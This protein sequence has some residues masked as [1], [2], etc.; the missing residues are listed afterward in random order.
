MISILHCIIPSSPW[1]FTKKGQGHPNPDDK[2]QAEK[3]E[4][5]YLKVE[6]VEAEEQIL[7]S[8]LLV[9]CLF[10]SQWFF[11]LGREGDWHTNM[12]YVTWVAVAAW[13]HH[14]Q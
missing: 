1:D 2:I 13:Q 4:L 3:D 5:S 10:H 9:L 8:S 14:R 11:Q 6:Q 7:N 12:F